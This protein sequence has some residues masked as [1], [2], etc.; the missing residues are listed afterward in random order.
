[1]IFSIWITPFKRELAGT[2]AQP[3]PPLGGAHIRTRNYLAMWRSTDHTAT[4]KITPTTSGGLL[5]AGDRLAHWEEQPASI[6]SVTTSEN[7]S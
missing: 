1:L 6:G 5:A 2:L 7:M 3:Y 4:H